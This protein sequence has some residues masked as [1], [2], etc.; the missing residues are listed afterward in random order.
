MKGRFIDLTGKIFGH[1][2]VLYV[3]TGC[4]PGESRWKCRCECGNETVVRGSRLRGGDTRSCGCKRIK[5]GQYKSLTYTSWYNMV[6]RC[7]N[8]NNTHW[9][10]YGGRGIVVCERWRLFVNF[11]EDMG[12]RPSSSHSI[13]RN[14]L[15]RGYEPGNCEWVMGQRR[16]M[17][18]MSRNVH[19]NINGKR[20]CLKQAAELL[21]LSYT[22]VNNRRWRGASIEEAFE[23]RATTWNDA[24]EAENVTANLGKS[25]TNASPNAPDAGAA[26]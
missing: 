11:L 24:A 18:N 22:M 13:E 3:A 2:T 6:Q 12:E 7:T 23:G 9:D 1:L 26:P 21:G 17:A 5:H 4:G 25:P 14:K 15:D 10:R 8:R 19:V 16:Q 20:M